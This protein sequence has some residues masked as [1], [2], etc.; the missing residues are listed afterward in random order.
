MT[1]EFITAGNT[2]PLEVKTKVVKLC[3]HCGSWQDEVWLFF[4][5]WACEDCMKT[6]LLSMYRL[7]QLYPAGSGK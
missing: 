7:G 3:Q 4:G 6:R 2:G 1:S 5:E